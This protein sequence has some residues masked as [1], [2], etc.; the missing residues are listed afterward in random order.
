MAPT[1][2][3]SN[4]PEAPPAMAPNTVS[5]SDGFSPGAIIGIVIA[6]VC[7][8]LA[9]PLIAVLLRKYEKTRLRETPKLPGS[10]S[11]DSL[12]SIEEGHS[13]KSIIVTKE[14]S[15]SSVR[16][17]RVD[18]GIRRPDDVYAVGKERERAWSVT[19]VHAGAGK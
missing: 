12:R 5:R 13:L 19:E 6:I 14:L 15:R 3:A 18:S 17:E 7:L 2:V 16:M 8:I 11:G 4:I 9:V 1:P 10:S